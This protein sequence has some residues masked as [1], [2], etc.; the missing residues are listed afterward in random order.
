MK[1]RKPVPIPNLTH[2]FDSFITKLA[3]QKVNNNINLRY[4][5]DVLLYPVIKVL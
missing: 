1:M 2:Q 5:F 4:P 3:T